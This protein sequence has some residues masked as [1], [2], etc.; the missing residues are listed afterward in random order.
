[1]S[2]GLLILNLSVSIA[3]ILICIMALKLNAVVALVI[4]SLYMG[5]SCGLGWMET[6]NLIGSG[7]GSTMT[8]MGVSIIFGVII[9][10]LLSKSGGANV[11]AETMIRVFPKDKSL[12]ALA[13]TAFILSIPVFFDITFI[14]LIPIGLSIS[15][16][17]KK[18][19]AYIVGDIAIGGCTAHVLVPP[20]PNPL[21]APSIFGYDLGI[22]LIG[23]LI[24]GLISMVVVMKIYHFI[25]D[26]GFFKDSDIDESA[27][28]EIQDTSNE[29]A[30]EFWK[31]MLPII[32][33]LV[34]I[35]LG[36]FG[37]MLFEESPLLFKLLGSRLP[38]LL[39]GVLAAYIVCYKAI[40]KKDLDA[41]GNNALKASGIAAF[42]TAA[43][44]AFGSVIGATNIGSILVEKMGISGTS[45]GIVLMLVGFVIAFIFKV[46][47]GSGTVA[48]ITSMQIMAGFAG[49]MSIHPFFLAVAC[50]SGGMGPG[51]LNDSAFWVTANLSGLKV[52]GGLKTYTT[53]QMICAF[54]I[55]AFALILALVL[56]IPATWGLV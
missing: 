14:I 17:I 12:Y 15:K 53:S 38:A 56:P 36:T 27:V 50:L 46:A 21:A 24:L 45:G 48:G 13:V 10:E 41:V 40:G 32:L 19:I 2:S 55:F 1:M 37:N 29:N 3:I 47:Q 20:T 9:G 8:S 43:G 49:G 16:K 11:I 42:V 51:H 33:P 35:L 23:G 28:I 7:F 52:S 4:A 25:L 39:V 26:K 5:V 18:N 44:G 22:Q 34:C 30:P 54:V 6:V 31:A